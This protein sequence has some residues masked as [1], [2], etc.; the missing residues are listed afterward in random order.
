[1]GAVD[2][3]AWH[4][5]ERDG[6]RDSA[7]AYGVLPHRRFIDKTLQ[8]YLHCGIIHAA[9]PC[10]KI[11]P[12]RR[13][14]LG[15]YWVIYKTRFGGMFSF[16]YDQIELAAYYL[17]FRRLAQ[18]W[19]SV[20]PSQSPSCVCPGKT[21]SCGSTKS[22]AVRDRQCGSGPP[23]RSIRLPSGSGGTMRSGSRRCARASCG[24]SRTRNWH[25]VDRGHPTN[26]IGIEVRG[27][28]AREDGGAGRPSASS[29]LAFLAFRL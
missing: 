19:K 3:G 13:H 17:A 20:L 28:E 5:I 2:G 29:R 21:K 26:N 16:A 12:V 27:I 22:G 24:K 15:A 8:N 6:G 11:I 18:H 23:G 10:A 14:P 9:L 7:A 1:V 25:S 4:R